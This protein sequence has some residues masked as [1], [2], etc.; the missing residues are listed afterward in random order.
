MRRAWAYARLVSDWTLFA[1]TLLW[2][3]AGGL[4]LQLMVL[5]YLLPD[6]HWGHGLIAGLDWTSFHGIAA[7]QA[8]R[9]GAEGWTAWE[10]RPGGQF[11]AGLA[12]VLYVL[13][14]PEP[15]VILP[16]N[17][18]LFATTVVAV[19]RLLEVTFGSRS[20]ATIGLLPF[21]AY[22]SFVPIWGQI[23]KDVVSGAGFGLV[24]MALVA[25]RSKAASTAVAVLVMMSVMGMTMLWLVRPYAVFLVAG[26]TIV[27]F[28]MTISGSSCNRRRL[29]V[30]S[31]AVVACA[32]LSLLES[33][34]N[35]DLK[36]VRE[37]PRT[38]PPSPT[39][40]TPLPMSSWFPRTRRLDPSV[41]ANDRALTYVACAPP[42]TSASDVV[43]RL[44][45]SACLYREGF[46][47]SGEDAGSNHDYDIQMRIPGDYIAYIPR[48]MQLAVLEPRPARWRTEQSRIG[49]LATLF[50]PIEMLMAYGAFAAALLIA[51]R[52]LFR[53]DV[54]AIIACCMTYIAFFVYT[55]PNMGTVY[56]MRA[57][58]FAMI[59]SVALAATL[60]RFEQAEPRRSRKGE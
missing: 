23:H 4:A 36:L 59:V 57:Y 19:R 55:T 41:L 7:A 29:S 48:A 44:L 50:V 25:A 6:L 24:V 2:V 16:V 40:A 34:S 8:K 37:V 51:R 45:F 46:R 10:L 42:P 15:W 52:Q 21:F 17:G 54:L 58:P 56:R 3:V 9:I 30:V 27:Y 32:C 47:I 35:K 33:D 53:V 43:D 1:F 39:E 13:V 26:A 28:V 38:M 11:P 20:A 5:P 22:L 31:A 12:S 49:K 60:A 18:L 14:T